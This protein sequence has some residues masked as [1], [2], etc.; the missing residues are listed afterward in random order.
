[1]S[2]RP[3][4]SRDKGRIRAVL[5]DVDGTLYA[6]L[7]LR[8]AMA[9]E[10]VLAQ[11]NP[12]RM[13]RPNTLV[14]IRAFRRV[15]EAMRHQDAPR[16]IDTDQYQHVAR[17]LGC[18]ESDVRGA[19][20]EWIYRRPL[21][22]LRWVR[23]PGLLPLLDHLQATRTR[24]GVFSDYPAGDKLAAL[25][26]SR[27]FDLALS[28]VDPEIEAFKP[29]PRGFIR[30]CEKWG[31][32]PGEVL[33]VGDRADVDGAGATAAGMRYALLGRRC[34]TTSHG[35]VVRNFEELKR[36]ISAHC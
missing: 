8:V 28:A 27:H 23:R 25:G 7:P 31:L 18:A 24:C 11:A 35:W 6:Q 13:R 1:M 3:A 29:H 9:C 5:F 32:S 21:K 16:S 10:L 36:V 12:A 4:V 17:L 26:V 19:V 20:D 14:T 30:A 22:W 15:R 34:R 33:Y 2:S